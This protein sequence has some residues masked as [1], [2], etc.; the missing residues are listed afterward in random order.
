MSREALT[1]MNIGLGERDIDDILKAI[2][3]TKDG[4][5]DYNEFMKALN[6]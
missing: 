3:R 4:N 6:M 2:D 1:K 5:I